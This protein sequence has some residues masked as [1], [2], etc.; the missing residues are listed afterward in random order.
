[1]ETIGIPSVAWTL[2]PKQRSDLSSEVLHF[3]LEATL[4][5]PRQDFICD[6]SFRS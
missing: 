6:L 1:M 3:G 4:S 5:G 2:N